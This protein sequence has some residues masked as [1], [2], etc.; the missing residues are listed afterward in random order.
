MLESLVFQCLLCLLGQ[1]GNGLQP[2]PNDLE[3][4]AEMPHRPRPAS[5]PVELPAEAPHSYRPT[6]PELVADAL[7]LPPGH[8]LTGQPVTLASALAAVRDPAQQ[9][10]VVRA[11]WRLAEA[12]AVYRFQL[13]SNRRLEGVEP[14]PG[15]TAR[16]AAARAA[17]KAQLGETELQVL[18]AQHALVLHARLPTNS[19]LPLPVDRPHVGQYI[20]R[21]R[22]LF[23]HGMAPPATRRLDR[24]LPIRFRAIEARAKAVAAAQ[25]AYEAASEG[26]QWTGHIDSLERLNRLQREW[27]GAVCHYNQEIA[28]YAVAVAPPGTN[29]AALVGLLIK[30]SPAPVRP[31]VSDDWSGV[32]PAGLT[33]PVPE[34]AA[35]SP[36]PTPAQRPPESSG[37]PTPAVRPPAAEPTP[38]KRPDALPLPLIPPGEGAA[39]APASDRV[40]PQRPVVPIEHRAPE[41]DEEIDLPPPPE[42]VPASPAPFEA[43]GETAPLPNHAPAPAAQLRTVERSAAVLPSLYPGL[44]G[45]SPG[46]L[47]KQ[48]NL[49]LHWNR[50]LPDDSG[51]PIE[52]LAGLKRRTVDRPKLI[53]AYWTVREHAAAWQVWRQHLQWLDELSFAVA[54]GSAEAGRL[55]TARLAAEASSVAAH[56]ELVEAQFHLAEAVGQSSDALWPLAATRPHSGQYLLQLEA[57][58]PELARSWSVRR[59]ADTLPRL[60]A[61][62]GERAVAVVESDAARCETEAGWLDGSATFAEVLHALELQ[63]GHTLAFLATLTA[64][65]HTIADYATRILPDATP[66]EQLV[67]ALVITE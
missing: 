18:T 19:P 67:N 30:P 38:A 41:S 44:A 32:Q 39:T 57:L 29:G 65:N 7:M 54:E 27:I 25:E 62:V 2:T 11:Y 15:Q 33:E 58:P 47:A 5:L 14:P 53:A 17:S 21:F 34:P 24:T 37:E 8:T 35:G 66:D 1:A 13:D 60:S 45:R 50:S 59:P 48:L 10:E 9:L 26:G 46:V 23:A 4:P 64:Y 56:A 20:T 55:S 61:A 36:Q 22:E 42:N 51:A 28:E 40:L 63:T 52:L 3:S 49:S 16:M 31:L 43:D 6:P 12:V